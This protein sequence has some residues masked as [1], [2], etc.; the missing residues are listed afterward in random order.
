MEKIHIVSDSASDIPQALCQRFAIEII[1]VSLTFGGRTIREYYDI[2]PEQYWKVLEE[3]DEIPR[4]AQI[5]L[6]DCLNT[7]LRAKNNG[8]THV[9]AVLMNSAGSGGYQSA[10]VARDM[11][12]EEHGREMVIELIDSRSYS[13]VYGRI[14]IECARMREAGRS[15]A[16]IAATA[17]DMVRSVQAYLGVFNLRHLRRSG[18][19]SGGA[20]FVGDKLGLRPSIDSEACA[21]SPMSST[22]ASTCAKRS[23][24]IK[25]WACAWP[26]WRWRRPSAPGSRPPTCSTPGWT[27]PISTSWS[28]C[29]STA[30]LP[31]WS[32]IPSARR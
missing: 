11:F 17:R 15:F 3:S 20:A 21:P 16:A 10:C 30:A 7:F 4:T 26:A 12:Y 24:G 8:Y 32:A 31:G 9:V 29:C 1:P 27:P 6:N 28:T 25:T 14:V 19:I 18:R 2:T 23:G 5:S 22:A 13:Y